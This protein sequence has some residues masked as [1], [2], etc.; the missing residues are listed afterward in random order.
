[1]DTLSRGEWSRCSG[2]LIQSPIVDGSP[3][4]NSNVIIQ[5][6][7]H[8]QQKQQQPSIQEES[9]SLLSSN[10]KIAIAY[11]TAATTTHQND[12]DDN[13]TPQRQQHRLSLADSSKIMYDEARHMITLALPVIATYLLEMLPG[14]VSI[15]LVGHIH[16]SANGGGEHVKEYMDAAALAVMYMNL[17]ALSIGFGLA[18]AMDTLC[19]NAFG[20]GELPQSAP[21]YLTTGCL[22]LAAA[23]G[24]ILILNLHATTILIRLG[25]P[26]QVAELA[27][28]FVGYLVPGI[29][30]LLLYELVRKILQAANIALPMLYCALGGNLLNAGLGY[31]WIYYSEPTAWSESVLGP[32]H[33]LGAAV[34]RTVGNLSF[35]IFLA[36][37]LAVTGDWKQFWSTTTG[38]SNNTT[39]VEWFRQAIKGIPSFISLGVPGA[40]QL[41]FEWWAFEILALLSGLLPNAILAIGT[42]AILLNIASLVYML[43]LG[44]SI[45]ANVRIGNALGANQPQ[46]AA[47]AGYLAMGLSVVASFFVATILVVFRRALPFLFTHDKDIADYC[48]ELLWIAACFQLPDSINATVQGVFRGSGRQHIGAW[49]N[50]VA[51]YVVGLPVGAGLAYGTSQGLRGLWIGVSVG[52]F[53]VGVMGATVIVRSDWKKLAKDA[54]RRLLED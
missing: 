51:Y 43:Y 26:P 24:V 54:I 3:R 33:W 37:Y 23:F 14:I 9:T 10:N 15:I 6:H 11:G 42:N 22:V 5:H 13:D 46:R 30:A 36:I 34:A 19:S 27:G 53:V 45:A 20:A 47:L 25:Q 12:K 18:S 32:D 49:L 52:L 4:R 17:T 48:S 21:L 29:P 28:I 31:Y 35:P 41:C 1:M 40:L 8:Q 16:S 39:T 7:H 50:F 2:E 38:D 44:I